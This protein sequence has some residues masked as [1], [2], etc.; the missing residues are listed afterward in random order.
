[1]E[2]L[3]VILL[4]EFMN[5]F[6]CYRGTDWEEERECTPFADLLEAMCLWRDHCRS[7]W[8]LKNKSPLRHGMPGRA[9]SIQIAKYRLCGTMLHL[10]TF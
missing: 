6:L 1:M 10:L 7:K 3:P 2:E 8:A 9:S 4:F 5:S